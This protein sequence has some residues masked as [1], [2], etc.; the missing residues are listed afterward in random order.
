MIRVYFMNILSFC[1]IILMSLD[2]YDYEYDNEYD[3]E[4]DYDKM[5]IDDDDSDDGQSLIGRDTLDTQWI[6]DLENELMVKEYEMV[7]P[8][9][10]L[11][12]SFRFVYLAS[13]KKT[14]EFTASYEPSYILRRPNE[15]SQSELFELIHR[16][17]KKGKYYNFLSLLLYDVRLPDRR[18]GCSNDAQWLSSYL[19]DAVSVPGASAGAGASAGENDGDEY[20]RVIEYTNLLSID[21]IYFCPLVS[22]F[23]SLIGFTVLLYE[24]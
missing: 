17:Q 8:T 23:H 20:G 21:K 12:V 11:R 13:D 24:D 18:N 5:V 16:F 3:N 2:D 15:I 22:L 9:D 19:S 4:Y 10:I 7:L 1:Y 6:T 14:I